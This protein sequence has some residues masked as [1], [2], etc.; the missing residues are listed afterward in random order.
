M[1]WS[2]FRIATAAT[3]A[4]VLVGGVSVVA[5]AGLPRGHRIH[6]TAYFSDTT[7][8]FVGDSVQILGIPVG[9]VDAIEPQPDRA[10]VSFSY[11][12]TYPVPAEAN[13]V[14]LAPSLVTARAIQM[15]PAYNGGAVLA[16]NA[17]IPQERTAVPI[18]FDE[19]RD[20]LQ[21]LTD[22][23]QPKADSGVS[24]LGAFVDTAAANLRGQGGSIRDALIKLSQATSALGDHS[25][26]IYSTVRSLSLVVSALNDSADVIEHLNVD[27]A[28]TT[29]LLT[30]SEDEVG[31]AVSD[32][33]G[34]VADVAAFVKANRDALG[35]SSD[36][37][38]SIG[39]ALMESLDDVKQTLHVA[40]NTVQN[41][42]NVYQPAQG[43]ISAVPVIN[44]LSNPIQFICSAVQAASRL[45]AEQS[46]KLCVQYLAPIVKNRQYNFLPF[47]LNPF[48]GA[49]ARPNEV[50]YSEDWMRPDY[51]PP[52]AEQAPA[53]PA[54]PLPAEAPSPQDS[55]AIEPPSGDVSSVDPARGLEGLM[56][57]QEGGTP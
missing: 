27:L 52:Q 46:A 22:A 56:L 32:V 1:K 42:S 3:L 11:D 36:K 25:D 51:V 9:R 2:R 35:T 40:P 45:N 53:P 13:A 48:V 47:G 30:N 6:V 50:T 23:L 10:K 44:T 41:F 33:N 37:L 29:S 14:I 4:V 34:V 55:P 43:A 21:R 12:A 28:T 8:L 20:Q 31:R 24:T 57:P 26:D 15:T 17:V 18:E 5:G 16:D 7:G 49:S 54:P 38:A 39:T 19:L